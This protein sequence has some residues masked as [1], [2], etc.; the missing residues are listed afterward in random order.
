MNAMTVR[1]QIPDRLSVP[2]LRARWRQLIDDPLVAAIPYKIELNERGSIE[3]S[4]A[5]T[6]HGFLQAYLA[7]E[8]H[9]LR[10]DGTTFTECP[11]ETAI[12][13]RV[14]DVTWAS[15]DFVRRHGMP[16]T[17]PEAPELCIEVISPSN[18]PA[19]INEK[20][21]AYLA[22]GAHEVWLVPEMGPLEIFTKNGRQTA[23][24][25]GFELA[26]PE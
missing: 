8:L 26:P 11:V 3:V 6:R 17:L 15:A 7:R 13:I 2:Q 19:E 25:L 18:T 9:R 16:T 20:V 12:G 10:A 4:P 23:S 14:P 5:S 22:A 21:T 1:R 24:T